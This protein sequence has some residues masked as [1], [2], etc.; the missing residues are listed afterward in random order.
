VAQAAGRARLFDKLRPD[1]YGTETG[2]WSKWFNKYLRKNLSVV[3]ERM[4]FHSFRHKF[5]DAARAVGIAEDVSDALTGHSSGNVARRY[6][7]PS[8]PLRPLVE[9][10]R[11]YRI[12][13]FVVP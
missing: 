13:G 5:K 7:G 3:D 6:G 2:N 11:R 1:S 8:Y 9:A 12:P 10:M 4:V